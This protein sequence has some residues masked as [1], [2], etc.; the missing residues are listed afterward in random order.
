MN[1][2]VKLLLWCRHSLQ[3]FHADQSGGAYT[4]S[5]AMVFP[6]VMLLVAVVVETTLMLNAKLGTVYAAYATARAVSVWSSQEEWPQVE[7][8]A[9]RVASMSMLAFAS[10]AAPADQASEESSDIDAIYRGWADEPVSSGYLRAKADYASSHTRAAI[11]ERPSDWNSDVV[12]KV[13][14]EYPFAISG[15][16]PLLGELSANGSYRF[17]LT[18]EVTL[19]NEG[20]QNAAQRLGI[21]YDKR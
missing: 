17:T 19:Q 2:V 21:G 15:L 5:Y 8:R 18:T 4:L 12:V 6:V 16:G 20:P 9:Q 1:E 13:I 10:G 11:A 7:A 14:Y 3:R